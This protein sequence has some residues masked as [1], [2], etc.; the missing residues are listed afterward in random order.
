MREAFVPRVNKE[1]CM[2]SVSV[3]VRPRGFTLIELLVVIAIIAILVPLRLTAVQQARE[4]DRKSQC[5]DHLHTLVIAIH[6][7]ETNTKR[8]PP[9]YIV[10]TGSS[11]AA[12][13]WPTVTPPNGT[14]DTA[15]NWSWQA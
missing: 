10:Q 15:G 3:R 14:V 5:Q 8:V 1:H 11:G 9:G 6:N 13:N 4:A 7:Y 2:S 12:P